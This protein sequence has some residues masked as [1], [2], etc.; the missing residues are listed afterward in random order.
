M[1]AS[2]HPV[3]RVAL[4]PLSGAYG[5]TFGMSRAAVVARLGAPGDSFTKGVDVD[6]WFDGALQVFHASDGS[7]VEY[8]EVFRDPALAVTCLGCDVFGVSAAR[9]IRQIERSSGVA[10]SERERRTHYVFE[11]LELA[12]SRPFASWWGEG[13]RFRSVGIGRPGYFS[14]P[15]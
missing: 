5:I 11:A 8:V 4:Q 12:L 6:A 2:R 9:A 14:T 10:A 15:P 1:S 7:G 3:R 13:R